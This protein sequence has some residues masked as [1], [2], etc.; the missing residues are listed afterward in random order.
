MSTPEPNPY[1]KLNYPVNNLAQDF[2]ATEKDQV[3]QNIGIPS[4]VN[5][6]GKVLKVDDNTGNLSWEDESGGGGTVTDVTVNG[7]SVVSG[8]VASVTVPT[9]TSDLNNDSGFITASDIPPQEQSD[10]NESNS[11]SAAY[12]QNKPTI[13]NVPDVGSTDNGK[14][15][16]ASYSGG[17]GSYSWQPASGGGTAEV[18]IVHGDPIPSAEVTEIGQAILADKFVIYDGNAYLS[19]FRQSSVDSS[20]FSIEWKSCSFGYNGWP[21]TIKRYYLTNDPRDPNYSIQGTDCKIYE[22]CILAKDY[23]Q[24]HGISF[25]EIWDSTHGIM[26]P[27]SAVEV[28]HD[29]TIANGRINIVC[30]TD[31]YISGNAYG[32]LCNGGIEVTSLGYVKFKDL[33]SGF[34]IYSQT[35]N[36]SIYPFFYKIDDHSKYV[37]ST[38]KMMYSNEGLSASGYLLK[39]Y[40]PL[41][42]YNEISNPY[43][44]LDTTNAGSDFNINDLSSDEWALGFCIGTFAGVPSAGSTNNY[45]YTLDP[46]Y[47][48]ED[49]AYIGVKNPVPNVD[50][51][52]DK[53][54][55]LSIDYLGRI[56]WLS[57]EEV[58]PAI[59]K[60][61]VTP[62]Y[63]VIDLESTYNGKMLI[64]SGDIASITNSGNIDSVI[65]QW[66]VSSSTTLPTM[67]S[68]YHGA[69]SNPSSLT[70]GKT[71]Q[72]RLVNDCYT[73][74]EFN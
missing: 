65:I 42:I 64:S 16:T 25:R 39:L 51:L 61:S 43:L 14:V 35:D 3:R 7:T 68:G 28:Q 74:E 19:Y 58:I 34:K 10:W 63:G 52:N 55:I 60:I 18:I 26:N 66:I 13:K 6:A 56:K 12:I 47:T 57:H 22:E 4:S 24:S 15:L 32:I 27:Y 46:S 44:T 23:R 54:K 69:S 72:L 33:H 1:R 73:I 67:P 8:G 30:Q 62:S 5:K 40:D 48:I 50:K 20:L 21:Y 29:G 9:K 45:L 37:T 59:T 70:V 53:G 71:Y 2:N 41:E 11:S 36:P 31:N 17:I 49:S 38:T